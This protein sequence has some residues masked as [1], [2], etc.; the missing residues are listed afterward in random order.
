MESCRGEHEQSLL[1]IQ[2]L[3][4]LGD[5]WWISLLIIITDFPPAHWGIC[6]LSPYWCLIVA[7]NVQKQA[8]HVATPLL[9]CGLQSLFQWTMDKGSPR[10]QVLWPEL[11]W[12]VEN[13]QTRPKRPKSQFYSRAQRGMSVC[14]NSTDSSLHNSNSRKCQQEQQKISLIFFLVLKSRTKLYYPTQHL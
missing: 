4:S 1:S 3:S 12:G 11:V 5:D 10:C 7:K 2:T 14:H 6:V 13:S 8:C 9:T